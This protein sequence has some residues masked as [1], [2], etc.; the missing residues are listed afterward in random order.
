MIIVL[1]VVLAIAMYLAWAYLHELAHLHAAR[2]IVGV[3]YHRIVP[4]PHWHLGRFYWARVHYDYDRWPTAREQ[5]WISFAPRYANLLAVVLF[6]LASFL[7]GWWFWTWSIAWGAGLVDL[8][9]GSTGISKVHDLRRT[10]HGWGVSPWVLRIGGFILIAVSVVTWA[11][12]R[13]GS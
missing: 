5:A 3:K 6:P 12:I 13:W 4:W 8:W 1:L 7:P 11:G 9:S 10:A 2:K